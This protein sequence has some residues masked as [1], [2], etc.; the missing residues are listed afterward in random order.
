MK[1]QCRQQQPPCL[2]RLLEAVSPAGGVWAARA[3]S[4][5]GSVPPAGESRW[6]VGRG[7]PAKDILLPGICTF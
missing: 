7:G 3:E 6:R 1:A 5:N 2:L 4:E